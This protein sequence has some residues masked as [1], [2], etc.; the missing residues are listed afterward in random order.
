LPN[1]PIEGRDHCYANIRR[2]LLEGDPKVNYFREDAEGT[3]WFKDSLIV[4]KKVLDEAHM[5]RYSIHPGS[6]KMYHDPRG[7][8]TTPWY[9]ITNPS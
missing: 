1:V 7:Q 6:N 2:R 8:F 4:P 9:S 5:L 3:F